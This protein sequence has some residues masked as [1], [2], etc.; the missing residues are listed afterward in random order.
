MQGIIYLLEEGCPWQL[1]FEVNISGFLFN[2][3]YLLHFKKIYLLCG[4][5]KMMVIVWKWAGVVGLSG[6]RWDHQQGKFPC[7][8]CT[9]GQDKIPGPQLDA[10]Q[11]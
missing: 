8:T 2:L 3:I 10:D 9:Y 4:G 5:F 11:S 6:L 7:I 1:E